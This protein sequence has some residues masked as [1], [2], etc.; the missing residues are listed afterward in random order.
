MDDQTSPYLPGSIPDAG[1]S[2]LKALAATVPQLQS[3]NLSAEDGSFSMSSA[4]GHETS[5]HRYRFDG[6]LARGGM[7]AV[8]KGRDIDLGREVA[9]KV[10][11]E[12]H[13]G[14]TELLQRFVEEAQ[15]AG[16]LQHPG[17]TP[18]YELGQFPDHRPFFT[19]K[20]VRG[21]TL[22]SI[23]KTFHQSKE[24]KTSS[25]PAGNVT[26]RTQ[27][28]KIYEQICQTLAYAHSRRVI[29]RDL[30]PQNIMVGKFGEVQVMDWG[31]AK[32]L[33]VSPGQPSGVSSTDAEVIHAAEDSV[34]T[35]RSTGGASSIS[36][37]QSG[38]IMGTVS[39]MAPEQARGDT[40]L[41]DERSDVFGLGSILCEILTGQPAYSTGSPMVILEM[42]ARADLAPA[43]SRLDQCGADGEL[44]G[45]AKQCLS[46]DRTARPRHAGAL[47]DALSHYLS[48]VEARLK[49][50]EL[51]AVEA[52]TQAKEEKKRRRVTMQLAAG[53]LLTVLAGL[54][55]SLWQMMRAMQ[56]EEF[57]ISERDQKEKQKQRAE[58]NE[59]LAK[60]QKALAE[61]NAAQAIK[62]RDR[63]DQEKHI[64]LTVREFL[65]HN[66]LQK[67][68]VVEQVN[69]GLVR[70]GKGGVVKHDITIR[71]LLDRAAIDFSPQ[72][73]D[74]KFPKQFQV[75]AE[76]LQTIGE[77]YEAIGDEK[78]S[79]QFVKASWQL[80]EKD[81][82]VHHSLTL[83][84][85]TE[86][87]FV[88]ISASQHSDA[89]RSLADLINRMNVR[90]AELQNAGQTATAL[91]LLDSVANVIERRLDM[92]RHSL[93]EVT[94]GVGDAAIAL[95]QLSRSIGSFEKFAATTA[96]L[97]GEDDRRTWYARMILGFAYHA[98][99]QFRKA[100]DSYE[101]VLAKAESK[102]PADDLRIAGIRLVLSIGYEALGIEEDKRIHMREQSYAS[103]KRVLGKDHPQTLS[104]LE[105]LAV[106]YYSVGRIEELVPILEEIYRVRKLQFEPDH[107]TFL[108]AQNNHA[109][110]YQISGNHERALPLHEDAMKRARAKLGDDHPATLVSMNNLAQA[111][112]EAAQYPKSIALHEEA[113]R[114]LI[115]KV[116]KNDH[117]V[118][119]HMSNLA[120]TYQAAGMYAK[121]QA[122]L[123]EVLSLRQAKLGP[124]HP[125]TLTSMGSLAMLFEAMGQGE[126]A[127]KWY[128]DTL[129][130]RRKHLGP[131]HPDMLSSI[132]NLASYYEDAKKWE[133]A[134]ARY[135]EVLKL[136]RAKYGGTHQETLEYTRKLAVV[137]RTMGK[138]DQSIVL[139]QE[140]LKKCSAKDLEE[141]EEARLIQS[142]LGIS[143]MLAGRL[144]EAIPLLE[145]MYA[146]RSKYRNLTALDATLIDAY[147][148]ANKTD[149]L[150]ALLKTDGLFVQARSPDQ[151]Q[152]A[153][154]NLASACEILLLKKEYLTCEILAQKCLVFRRMKSPGDWRVFQAEAL[155]GMA[156]LG[157]RQYA[158]A[159]GSLLSSHAGLLKHQSG[160]P[161]AKAGLLPTI[162]GQLVSLYEATGKTEKV[163]RW[164]DIQEKQKKPK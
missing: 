90:V 108:Q 50:A 61:A 30:K 154:D 72:I 39:Y 93:P 12:T 73:I 124:T 23:L 141:K 101:K 79:V 84:G 27:L 103:I 34:Q 95:I 68:S 36:E 111:Y 81:L 24:S 161:E 88:Y 132:N 119:Q 6:E 162:A 157:L 43:F 118:H 80:L 106:G 86:L 115:P 147:A 47:T 131:T 66:L 94:F 121:A 129:Q 67:A 69:A 10:M 136:A 158:L 57:A 1:T 20:L 13:R 163:T 52:S 19:M 37:T 40:D 28:L 4:S 135:E 139:M 35:K 31:L 53:I 152:E 8:L 38:S 3:V 113:I 99:G 151:T 78:K 89:C 60:E 133:P 51:A 128:E 33:R 142:Q 145:K 76:I 32:V 159:E 49:Q 149:K 104:C 70:T 122:N 25:G 2:V 138:I 91:L 54:G 87:V 137:L 153:T 96:G 164:R 17:I 16:Q 29:H 83:E 109:A 62:E 45:I 98:T 15:I 55:V 150:L 44:I 74:Q 97:C 85:M 140:T 59:A 148:R 41:V 110:A 123:E 107:P 77:A 116:G 105:M 56:A 65:Q 7:G 58:I 18:V 5:I 144:D 71:E 114:L 143:L 42:A 102:L 100:V 75:Q 120:S 134:A 82:G 11:L 146:L 21:E 160:I 156:Q 130:L 92:K 126:K 22:A 26:N 64:A 112:H 63:A 48:G 14:K 9:V 46:A 155:L 117:S 125:L 127:L